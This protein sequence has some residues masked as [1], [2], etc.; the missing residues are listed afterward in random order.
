MQQKLLGFHVNSFSHFFKCTKTFLFS[1]FS[2][3]CK[4]F[5]ANQ[6]FPKKERVTGD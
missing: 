4:T 5:D 1:L 3:E 2:V 6:T